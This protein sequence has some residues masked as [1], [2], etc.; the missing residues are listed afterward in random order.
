MR[1]PTRIALRAILETFLVLDVPAGGR[2]P[3]EEL[4]RHWRPLH[5]RRRDF[6]TGLRELRARGWI[7]VFRD[8]HVTYAELTPA[9]FDNAKVAPL[10]WERA[11]AMG[12]TLM[13]ALNRRRRRSPRQGHA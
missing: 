9:G 1:F 4:R 8:D 10:P 2:I 5:V 13:R 11:L 3:L 7:R 12:R 6:Y